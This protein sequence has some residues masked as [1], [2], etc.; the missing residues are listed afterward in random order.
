[1]KIS[2]NTN[3]MLI[4]DDKPYVT[5]LIVAAIGLAFATYG[6]YMIQHFQKDGWFFVAISAAVFYGFYRLIER[7]QIIF[8]RAENTVEFRRRSLRRYKRDSYSLDRIEKA[9]VDQK[10]HT[11]SSSSAGAVKSKIFLLPIDDEEPI[12]FTSSYSTGSKYTK[13][14]AIVN[15]WL[16]VK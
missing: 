9:L 13:I 10:T 14:A 6:G 3:E 15:D 12:P 8:D 2:T 4:V 1:M 5:G 11:S 7:T 16:G